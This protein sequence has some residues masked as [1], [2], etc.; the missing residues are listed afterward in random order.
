MR[1]VTALSVRSTTVHHA[2]PHTPTVS[3]ALVPKPV[4]VMVKVTFSA[5]DVAEIPCMTGVTAAEN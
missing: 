4:P 1:H 5:A 3:A 2:P